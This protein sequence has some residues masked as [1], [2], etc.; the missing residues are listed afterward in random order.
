MA[1]GVRG[2][3]A[4]T[5]Y[6]QVRTNLRRAYDGAAD[7]RDRRD[8]PAWKLTER[9]TFL[10]H[11]QQANCARLL[12]IGAGTGHDSAFFAGHGLDVVATDISAAMV[13]RCREKGLDARVIELSQFDFPA[14]SFDAVRA[15]N[16]LLHVPNMA[17]PLYWHRLPAFS[18]PAGCSSSCLRH[19]RANG[20]R[21][22]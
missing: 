20:R 11:L 13:E 7:R 22:S 21:P 17:R 15:I 9:E 10:H 1:L 19:Q 12:E 3:L 2:T 4:S 5:D 16:C 14:E 6:Q 8:K 18:G